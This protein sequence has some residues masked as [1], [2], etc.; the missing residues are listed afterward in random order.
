[1]VTRLDARATASIG[2]V[3][4]LILV[5]LPL[6]GS[7]QGPTH[8]WFSLPIEVS[9]LPAQAEL[10]PIACTIDFADVLKRLG[11][12]AGV[13]E[14][15]IRLFRLL[16]GGGEKEVLSQFTAAPQA[17]ANE[18]QLLPGTTPA[19][20]YRAEYAAGDG[21]RVVPLAGTLAWLAASGSD[22]KQAYR[23]RFG[24]PR[25]G[26]FVQVPFPPQNYRVF[27]EQGRATPAAYFPHMQI[28]P[29]WPLDGT[30]HVFEGTQLITT[31]HLGP[32]LGQISPMAVRRPFLYPVIGPD[33]YGLTEF[34]KPHDPTGSHAH[35]YS[36]WIAHANVNGHD[37]WS[38]RGGIIAHDQWE[39]LEDGPVFCRLVLTTRWV[40]DKVDILRERRSLTVYRA[41]APT[42]RLLDFELEFMPAGS[43]AVEL[44]KT[45]FGFLAVRVAQSMTP[46]DGGGEILSS[47]GDRNE[48]AAHLKRA[49]WL[50]L[51]G[52]V[53]PGRAADERD[54]N[55]PPPRWGGIAVFDHPANENHPTIWHC[56]NDGWAG[57]SFCGEKAYTIPP[58]GKLRLRYRLVLHQGTV[59]EAHIAKHYEQ[60]RAQ[61]AIR[62]GD[63]KHD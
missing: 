61:P 45:S 33:G 5:G 59:A 9:G 49:E 19:V 18:R 11:V 55:I 47:R 13:D 10:V 51:S 23:L 48:Q 4:T 20:S 34:G 24:V 3:A 27:D 30:L 29:Q 12:C 63:P 36:L 57:A 1:M 46:F 56:R 50:D 42:A 44:G 22:G 62:L 38:E 60:Y 15:S 7:A 16:P 32:L 25:R 21:S 8:R 26:R 28:R 52:P 31:Y 6:R 54:S 17:R 41:A 2:F 14:R 53:A 58:A 35:H 43:K 37:F 39:L 40:F